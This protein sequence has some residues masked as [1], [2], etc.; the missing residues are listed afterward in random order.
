[1]PYASVIVPVHKRHATLEYAVES[2]RQQTV[3]DIEIILA[4]DGCTERVR[5]ICE[6][7]AK[8]DHR[9]RFL[10]FPKAPLRGVLNRDKAVRL[11]RAE[12]IFYCD[13]DD[14]FLPHHIETLGENLAD[15]DVADTPPVTVCPEGNVELGIH[16]SG[17]E[18]QKSLLLNEKFKGVFDTHLAHTREIYV[19]HAGAWLKADDPRVVLHMLKVFAGNKK[20]IW[21]TINRITALSLHGARR[22]GMSASE[23]ECEMKTWAERIVA[24]GI[25]RSLREEGRYSQHLMKLLWALRHATEDER[26]KFLTH[27]GL[28]T[29][30]SNGTFQI[31]T[32]R[33]NLHFSNIHLERIGSLLE[34]YWNKKSDLRKMRKLVGVL[35]NPL[36]GPGFPSAHI[37]NLLSKLY[38]ESEITE[39]LEE[40]RNTKG[41]YL[42]QIQLA[43]IHN[44]PFLPLLD[45]VRSG[46]VD[47]PTY[48]KF[49]FNLCIAQCLFA[50]NLDQ[51]CFRWCN[52]MLEFPTQTRYDLP[53]WELRKSL[54][55]KMGMED[56]IRWAN[57]QISWFVDKI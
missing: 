38:N 36:L 1:M 9:V 17:H 31:D 45:K 52:Y 42:A 22:A 34:L 44:R 3:A 41:G 54:V 57:Q 19:S 35:L 5:S 16:D 7:F 6:H 47:I 55:E 40:T 48:D 39:I 14:F 51:E 28:D 10:D 27:L 43:L 21:K 29:S 4:G 11:A 25:E 50:K 2:I 26:S 49:F 56:E 15:C 53:Y 32:S 23:R 12:K 46:A 18:V 8:L 30:K 20:L 24:P 33:S 37:V 13:D